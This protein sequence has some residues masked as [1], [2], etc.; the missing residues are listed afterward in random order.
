M[1]GF[2]SASPKKPGIVCAIKHSLG[3]SVVIT[4]SAERYF[5]LEVR[6]VPGKVIFCSEAFIALVHKGI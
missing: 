5:D 2:T 3:L 4:S 6:D 1:S